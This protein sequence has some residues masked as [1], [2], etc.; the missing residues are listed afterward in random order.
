MGKTIRSWQKPGA[1]QKAMRHVQEK[2]RHFGKG[3]DRFRFDPRNY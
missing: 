1:K 2:K 3:K